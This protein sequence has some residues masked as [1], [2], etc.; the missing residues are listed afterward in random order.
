MDAE[1]KQALEKLRVFWGPEISRLEYPAHLV[2]TGAIHEDGAAA[3]PMP[4]EACPVCGT[5]SLAGTA[6]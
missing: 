2:E 4:S 5:E 1:R 6:V 3:A